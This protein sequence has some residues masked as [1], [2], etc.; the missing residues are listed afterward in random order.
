M[1]DDIF[2][3]TNNNTTP[4]D[5]HITDVSPTEIT[6]DV[7]QF[8]Y[9][10]FV[11]IK[12]GHDLPPKKQ[13]GSSDPYVKFLMNGKTVHRSKTI[14]KDLNP[15]WDESFMASVPDLSRHMEIRVFNHNLVKD[16]LIG[17]FPLDLVS[18]S[19]N[20][21]LDLKVSLEDA[22]TGAS[23]GLG[24]VSVGLNL[25]AVPLDLACQA[26]APAY[27]AFPT[28]PAVRRKESE[29]KKEKTPSS[30]AVLSL[31]LIEG[32]DILGTKDV[33]GIH[34]LYCK[35]RLGNES[36][37]SKIVSS[38]SNPRW[39]EQFDLLIP[40]EDQIQELEVKVKDLKSK[41]VLVGRCSFN[42][43]ALEKEKSHQVWIDLENCEG[44]LFLIL[45][46]TGTKPSSKSNVRVL[47][48]EQFGDN[49][50]SL[51]I[52]VNAAKG[53][54][55][56]KLA[57]YSD[58]FCVVEL[59]NS[60]LQTHVEYKSLAPVWC[61]TFLLP[62]MDIHSAV[63]VSVYDMDKNHKTELLGKLCVPLLNIESNTPKWFALK[64]KKLRGRAKG[65]CPRIE[66]EFD[67]KWNF[68]K[69]AFLT[70]N[71]KDEVYL[72]KSE[73]FKRRLL[74]NN[75]IRI[76]SI[77]AEMKSTAL[78]LHSSINWE[79]RAWTAGAFLVFLTVTFL[80]ELFML[81]LALSIVFVQKYVANM[82]N[83]TG[84]GAEEGELVVVDN[85]E[86][87]D[88]DKEDN[89]CFA[90]IMQMVQDAFPMV[91]N[92]LG[93]V[94][95]AVEKLKNTLNW[96]VPFLSILAVITLI[97]VS[98]I[99]FFIP[100]RFIIMTAGSIKFIKNLIWPGYVDNNEVIDFMSR[101][102]DD[103]ILEDSRE[104][105]IVGEETEV[106]VDKSKKLL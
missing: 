98:I 76:K 91:Q 47:T 9:H 74:N 37:K 30:P 18:L 97:V 32:K 94:A 80:F 29:L 36:C 33:S 93:L 12:A 38:S 13:N 87:I 92:Y 70:V 64:D 63:Y 81:P 104:L 62:V 72:K 53:L 40:D 84:S 22:S 27:Q 23:E 16:D 69:A 17:S 45:A 90:K 43:N 11:H 24:S 5:G 73:K 51:S 58:V 4:D 100:V 95:S 101:V 67:L 57:G 19:Q 86:E 42:L 71:P 31:S 102:P 88:I 44:S 61:K 14:H 26:P 48:P 83:R 89:I 68:L 8:Q 50:G 56:A 7:Q 103:E 78:A 54:T 59:D 99:L 65:N 1:D 96:T 106:L 35:F 20:K 41:D 52:S 3:D 15:N 60:R 105:S 39:S 10:L 34:E 2:E 49:L 75:V 82:R 85:R 25:V 77:L 28:A 6:D 55:A 21:S 79:S 66:L 46:V